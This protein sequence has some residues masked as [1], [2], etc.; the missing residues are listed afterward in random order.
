CSPF[1]ARDFLWCWIWLLPISATPASA[2]SHGAFSEGQKSFV[3]YHIAPNRNQARRYFR[4]ISAA[5]RSFRA[6]RPSSDESETRC[7]RSPPI[8]TRSAASVPPATAFV[9]PSGGMVPSALLFYE[10]THTCAR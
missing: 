3:G 7:V 1:L 5:N 4:R 10:G 9:R 2:G 8:A 6:D